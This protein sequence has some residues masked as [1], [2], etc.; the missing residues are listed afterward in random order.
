MKISQLLPQLGLGERF[1]KKPKA[2]QSPMAR[3]RKQYEADMKEQLVELKKKG[4]SIP[5]FTL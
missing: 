2:R 1:G 3:E 4:L 5:V